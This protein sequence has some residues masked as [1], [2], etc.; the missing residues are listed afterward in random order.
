LAG[1]RNNKIINRAVRVGIIIPHMGNEIA[2]RCIPTFMGTVE[3]FICSSN[4]AKYSL[5]NALAFYS[6]ANK[7]FQ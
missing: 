6:R 1:S 4:S 7:F 2:Q 5:K 3:Y